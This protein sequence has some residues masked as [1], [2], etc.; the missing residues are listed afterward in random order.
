RDGVKSFEHTER[1]GTATES[2]NL[3]VPSCGGVDIAIAPQPTDFIPDQSGLLEKFA[4]AASSSRNLGEVASLYR[5]QSGLLS[6]YDSSEDIARSPRPD[7]AMVVTVVRQSWGFSILESNHEVTRVRDEPDLIRHIN[8]RLLPDSPKTV[9]LVLRDFTPKKADL[10]EKNLDFHL[11]L[12]SSPDVTL[13]LVPEE[14]ARSVLSEG[15][16]VKEVATPNIQRV[17]RG[18]F[19][20]QY[21]QTVTLSAQVQSAIYT[22]KTH[23]Y[24]ATYELA[25]K[26]NDKL[27]LYLR[28]RMFQVM[29]ADDI[30]TF[31]QEELKKDHHGEKIKVE[32]EQFK[33][34]Y[35]A[36]LIDP[37]KKGLGHALKPM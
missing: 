27:A 35:V 25:L 17:E 33:Q 5:D 12:S 9:Y 29:S 26:V 15:V 3:W 22:I 8:S 20:G 4:S 36:R 23:I 34:T 2:L 31:I 6:L 21:L 13:Y 19:Q 28:Q 7:K 18:P 16:V 11:S 24:A 37:V 10:L 14:F 30:V 1:S 32:F